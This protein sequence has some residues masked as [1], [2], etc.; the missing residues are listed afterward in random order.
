MGSKTVYLLMADI[1]LLVHLLFVVFLVFGLV[2]IFIGKLFSWPWVR[3]PWFR[4]IHLVSMGIVVL[5]SWLSV[6]CPLTI[7]EMS[8]RGKAGDSVYA[9]SFVSYWLDRLLYYQ[10]PEW[11]FI[12]IYT[13]FGS[14]V[15]F[16]WFWI[17]P[18]PFRNLKSSTNN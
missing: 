10:A 6:I 16:S 14:L 5:Q 3:N 12:L 11:V 9:G 7:W 2:F 18:R 4:W 8:L 13:L 1:I 15:V 17:R